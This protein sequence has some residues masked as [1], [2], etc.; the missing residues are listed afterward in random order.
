MARPVTVKEI[1][2]R[3][4]LSKSTVSVALRGLPGTSGKLRE[5]VRRTAEK[6]GY[7]QNPLIGI[8]M[9]HVRN[10]RGPRYEATLAWI[11][12]HPTKDGLR[13]IPIFNEYFLGA[14]EQ[15]ENSGFR[16]EEFWL[17]A[18]GMSPDRLAR[19]LRARGITGLLLGPQPTSGCT[20]DL[21]W[22]QFSAVTI[23]YA[24]VSPR[25]HLI[26]NHHYRT[27]RGALAKLRGFGYR[28]VGTAI[29]A[30]N[31]SRVDHGWSAIVWEDYH[32][33]P[34]R[35]R[36]PPLVFHEV[37]LP[38][39]A[40]MFCEWFTRYRPDAIIAEDYIAPIH[41]GLAS[42]GLKAGR[43]VALALRGVAASD[44]EHAGMHQNERLIGAAAVDFLVGMLH[45]NERGIP[46]VP[47]RLLVESTWQPGP[48]VDERGPRTP[49]A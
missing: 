43:D 7:R 30:E 16:L 41:A 6:L 15:A 44:R 46:A 31:N 14:R 26:N 25:L 8:H 10:A 32:L 48:S 37:D 42:L 39:T 19:I 2:A 34:P 35:R 40:E 1:A 11:D 20:L 24:L 18:P 45:R 22:P 33:L 27:M 12:N 23:D 28:R 29:N 21:D 49:V 17:H 9:A 13:S 47:Q 5:K 3:L 36:I 38:L 4:G